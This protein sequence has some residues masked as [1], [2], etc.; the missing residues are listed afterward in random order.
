M[1]MCAFGGSFKQPRS[2]PNP[3]PLPIDPCPLCYTAVMNDGRF[4]ETFSFF[5]LVPGELATLL[6]AMLPIVEMRGAIPLGHGVFGLSWFSSYF[7]SYLGSLIP[8]VVIL[9]L[10]EPAIEWCNRK[11]PVCRRVIGGLLDKVRHHY[12]RHHARFGEIGVFI[13]C[14][15]PLP[16]LGVWTASA[17]AVIFG[18]PFRRALTLLAMGNA[19]ACLLVTLASMGVIKFVGLF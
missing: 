6:I 5:S 13:I 8:G 9:Y 15:L 4:L 19:V 2:A 7:W 1:V 11:S 18:I 3:R 10:T 17:G 16:L 12:H 14:S